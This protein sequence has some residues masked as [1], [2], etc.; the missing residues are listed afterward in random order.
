[1]RGYVIAK[2]NIAVF[3]LK[4]TKPLYTGATLEA[5]YSCDKTGKKT[6]E[7][8]S[9]SS[10]N[11]SSMYVLANVVDGNGTAADRIYSVSFS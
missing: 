9:I 2:N 3:K 11:G 4:G 7:V 10:P 1:M 8:E 6:F 5:V